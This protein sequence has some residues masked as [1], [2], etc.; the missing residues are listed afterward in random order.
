MTTSTFPAKTREANRDA[1]ADLMAMMLRSACPYGDG[2][3]DADGFRTYR[4]E[5]HC[6]AFMITARNTASGWQIKG[7]ITDAA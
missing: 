6:T 3:P 7:W 2:E 4:I 1:Q 5:T